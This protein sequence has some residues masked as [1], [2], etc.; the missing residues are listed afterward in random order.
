[1]NTTFITT[2]VEKRK[3]K[4]PLFREIID[5]NPDKPSNPDTGTI[6]LLFDDSN[7][8]VVKEGS[9]QCGVIRYPLN[10]FRDDWSLTNKNSKVVK[11]A[12]TFEG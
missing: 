6:V 8:I 1:M 5:L 7:G 3:L 11:G 2:I 4:Y 10:L 12:A 9:P